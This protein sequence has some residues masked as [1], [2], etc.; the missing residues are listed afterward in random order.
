MP[1]METP[2]APEP[3]V[4]QKSEPV[5]KEKVPTIG[6]YGGTVQVIL[7]MERGQSRIA[8][9]QSGYRFAFELKNA[10][11]VM[12]NKARAAVED[13]GSFELRAFVTGA[14]T[15]AWSSLDAALNEFILLNAVEPKSPLSETEKAMI[16]AIG[17]ED[18]RPRGRS[19]TLKLF[20]MLLRLLKKPPLVE[21]E[22]PYRSA[23]AVR[24]LRNELVHPKPYSMIVT[25]S[26]DPNENLSEQQ[27][28]V[29]QLRQDLSLDRNAIFPR[30]ILNS[31]CADWAVRS[32]ESFLREFVER[33]GV[34]PG[35]VTKNVF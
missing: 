35:F 24:L 1:F 30:D 23:E 11:R 26:E 29:R 32:C 8:R 3:K 9:V 6:P 14:V 27:K 10:A 21:N 16:E 33:S 19:S 25:F 18:L 28:I 7:D 22:Q 34:S 31:R 13:E 2:A 4:S 17:S 5:K 12:A 15:L 20:N